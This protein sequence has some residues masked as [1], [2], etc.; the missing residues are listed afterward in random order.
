MTLLATI[1]MG[2]LLL[3]HLF[4]GKIRFIHYIPRSPVLSAASGISV[5]YVFIHVL[6]ELI[7]RSEH[8]ARRMEGWLGFLEHHSL[9]MAL[10]GFTAFYGLDRL[11]LLSRKKPEGPAPDHATAPVF[12]IHLGSFALY[13]SLI[14]YILLNLEE[15]TWANLVLYTIAVGMHFVVNDF[16]LRDHHHH[17]YDRLGRWIVSAGLLVGFAVAL[18]RQVPEWTI[19]VIYA[20]LAGGIILNAIKEELPEQK[21]SRFWAFA[22]GSLGYAAVLLAVPQA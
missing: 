15:P 17:V 3:A 16:A 6:P 10:L 18:V 7:S 4:A 1:C 22:S 5:A 2:A 8:I 21:Q 19:A 11:A 12:W 20:F 14:G 9:I 13:N